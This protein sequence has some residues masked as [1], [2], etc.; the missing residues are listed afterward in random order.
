MSLPRTPMTYVMLVIFAVMLGLAAQWPE[1]ARF[2]PFVVGIPA[3]ALCLLQL[4]L[5]ARAGPTSGGPAEETSIADELRKAEARV[6]RMTGR[7]MHF[8]V[9]HDINLPEE[10]KVTEQ[11][12]ASR[13][14]QVWI[15][16]VCLLA[17]VILFGFA[18]SVPVFIICFLRWIAGLG[19]SRSVIY[20]IA[21]GVFIL[22]LFEFG[23]K[24]ELHKGL[25]TEY[26]LE[27]L[28][29]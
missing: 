11:A 16:L 12:A 22:L 15:A 9:A 4:L 23:L 1:E 8:D 7:Q 13:E 2:M 3:I 17:G 20:G 25:I 26:V 14:K 24:S 27:R 5:D 28:R 18:A 19:W 10:V 29:S 6:S 21:A